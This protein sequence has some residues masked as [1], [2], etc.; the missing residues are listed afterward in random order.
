MARIS[1]Y[2]QDPEVRGDDKLVGTSSTGDTQTYSLDTIANYFTENNVVTVSGQQNY[3]FVDALDDI[4][5]GTFFIHGFNSNGLSFSNV[6]A[7]C[8]SKQSTNGVD[9]ERFLRDMFELKI[10]LSSVEDPSQF[11]DLGIDR[12][13]DNVPYN[14]YLKVYV[15]PDDGEGT[16]T[17]GEIY[18]LKA[19]SN[20]NKTFEFVQQVVSKTWS[21]EH[22]MNKYPSVSIVDAGGNVLYTEV[23]YIDKNNLEVRFVASTSGKAYLN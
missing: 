10:R 23:E 8:I 14:G 17:A 16:L 19:L 4:N 6:L 3:K 2:N 1:T 11:V 12:I 15:T 13:E 9:I 5:R 20:V 21:I 7:F 22:N 18:S